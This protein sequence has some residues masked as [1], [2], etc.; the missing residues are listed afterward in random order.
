MTTGPPTPAEGGDPDRGIRVEQIDGT[1]LRVE[2]CHDG[3]GGVE[4]SNS[5]TSLRDRVVSVGG[6]LEVISPAG[7]GTRVT[8]LL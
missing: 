1:G 8:A 3:V 6:R 7:G 2:I 4:P 5:L